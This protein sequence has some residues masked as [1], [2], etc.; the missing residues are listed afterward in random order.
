MQLLPGIFGLEA[1]SL[2]AQATVCDT[3]MKLGNF[4]VSKY[5]ANDQ[6]SAE[7]SA[8]LISTAEQIFRLSKESMVGN[9]VSSAQTMLIDCC[10]QFLRTVCTQFATM[11]DALIVG[12]VAIMLTQGYAL[13]AK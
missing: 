4:Y 11:A 12:R 9:N 2:T 5:F 10:T 6:L 8:S 7:T 3:L 1:V 13:D